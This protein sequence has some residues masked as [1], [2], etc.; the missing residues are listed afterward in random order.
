[1]L[2]RLHPRDGEQIAQ[3]IEPVALRDVGQIAD[4]LGDEIGGFV[5]VAFAWRLSRV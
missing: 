1:M 2:L 3:V 4:R 5:A